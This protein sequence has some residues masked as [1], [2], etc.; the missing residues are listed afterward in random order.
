MGAALLGQLVNSPQ[1]AQIKQ[2][3]RSNPAA[4]Q[5]ILG[6]IQQSSPQLY[7]VLIYLIPAYRSKSRS[8]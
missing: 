1:F 3:I 7:Q 2:V 8:L 4:L 6:Q 5:P